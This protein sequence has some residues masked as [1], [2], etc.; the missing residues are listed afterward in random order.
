MFEFWIELIDL[1]LIIDFNMEKRSRVLDSVCLLNY[2][3]RCLIKEYRVFSNEMFVLLVMLI[4]LCRLRGIYINFLI[5]KIV[6]VCKY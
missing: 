2:G 4:K 5:S 3:F 6:D 1:K